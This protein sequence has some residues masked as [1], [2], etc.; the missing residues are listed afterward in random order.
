MN[1]LYFHQHFS[2]PQGSTGTRS[3]EMAKAL[4]KAGHQVT[5]VCGSFGSGDTGITSDFHKGIR[6][7][8]V[9]N[10]NIIEFELPYSNHDSFIKRTVI[11][12]KFALKS[13]KPVF[14]EKYDLV[15]ATST[16]LTAGI[17]GI[18]ARWLKNKKFIFE[19][20]DLWPEL[21]KEMG[22]I[23][24]PVILK[25][26]SILEWSSYHSAHKCIGLS[27]G[28][29][30]GIES[31]GIDKNNITMIPNGCDLELFSMGNIESKRPEGIDDDD[32]LA[33]FTGTHGLANG[34]DAAL[35]VAAE[36]KHRNVTNIKFCFIGQGKEKNKLVTRKEK[37]KLDNCIFLDPMPK[38]ELTSYLKGADIG[39]QMLKN[40]PVFYYGTS[41]NKFFDYLAAGLPILNNYPGWITD[42][43]NT[44]DLGFAI[45]PD[46]IDI[47]A[48]TLINASEN[49]TKLLAMGKNCS[50]FAQQ[51]DRSVL[52]TQFV[53]YLETCQDYK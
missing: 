32:L 10:I 11:F 34:V 26:M 50:V 36:L 24:N 33:I 18:V 16:P 6:R 17:P 40:V 35:D 39:L 46:N 31:R 21:P 28:I 22:V 5:I 14:T 13:I 49:K 44:N 30:Q 45:P 19:V 20:R 2:T 25:L 8:T 47:F 38:T 23:T 48:S 37:E 12:L 27:P 41:P 42:M 1:I 3:Y 15:F 43:V 7:A 4:I 29:V 52:S 9:D 51:F 53:E